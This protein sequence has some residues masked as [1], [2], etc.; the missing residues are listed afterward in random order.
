MSGATRG[1]HLPPP[2]AAPN[3]SCER[4]PSR[5]GLSATQRPSEGAARFLVVSAPGDGAPDCAI[6]DAGHQ[7]DLDVGIEV[8]PTDFEAVCSAE[9]W[10]DIYDRLAEL[11]RAHHTTLV[12]VNTRRLAERVAHNLSQRLDEQNV[13]SHHG[14]L[15]KERRLALEQRLKA[16]EMKALV[17]T[18]SL[19][20]G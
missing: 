17:A 9:Q 14:S 1:R 20:R 10:S 4:R 19:E 11:I 16:G 2:R 15:S 6:V 7:R 13:A 18:A 3:P 12:F 5:L 8:P